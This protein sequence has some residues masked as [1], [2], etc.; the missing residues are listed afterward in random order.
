MNS[1]ILLLFIPAIIVMVGFKLYCHD[2]ISWK[3]M[4]I[5]LV[6]PMVI[7]IFV[8]NVSRYSML[9]D[10]EILNGKV[11]GK[12]QEYRSCSHSYSCNCRTVTSGSG[13]NRSS[14]TVCDTC[15]EH[16]NDWDWEVYSTV[17]DF[18]IDRVDRRGVEEPS[19]WSIVKNDQPVAI[20]HDYVNYIQAAP[21]SLMHYTKAKMY[22]GP[23][24]RYPSIYDYQYVNRV[25]SVGGTVP[26]LEAWNAL[27]SR[28][29]NDLG[30]QRQ[31]NV[32]L[33]FTTKKPIFA[34]A[35]RAAWLGG[36][37][38]DVTVV[39]GTTY[40][41]I[42]WVRVFSWAKQDIINVA[43]RNELLESKTLDPNRTIGIVTQNI[44]R[45]YQRR[46][47]ADFAYLAEEAVPPTWTIIIAL[48]LSLAASV[49]LGI[50]FHREV[51]L[52]TRKPFR[53]FRRY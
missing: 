15:Y 11:T 28:S 32:N 22:K 29:L 25:Q 14:S 38:N 9:A 21:D 4:I 30:A 51:S 53:S 7:V 3:Q 36:K 40:P 12:K 39:I 35:L 41:T 52:N 6:V 10:T 27:L 24:P 37:K 43:L 16:S 42:R 23:L 48:I 50:M 46:P 19:R 31:V 44:T 5:Q 17:G 13:S 49:G 18:T 8:M 1:Y 34:D 47:M 26:N 2:T 20:E 45:Y 33:I